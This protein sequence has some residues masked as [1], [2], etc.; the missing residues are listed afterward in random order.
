[1]TAS[2]PNILEAGE[3]AATKERL[4]TIRREMADIVYYALSPR[5]RQ[6]NQFADEYQSISAAGLFN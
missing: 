2:S 3:N 5:D 1:M 4:L 6:S